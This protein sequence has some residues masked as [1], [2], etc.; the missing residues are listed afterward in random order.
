MHTQRV[1]A[2]VSL[3]TAVIFGCIA[4]LTAPFFTFATV[5]QWNRT[6]SFGARGQDV[7]E[8]Q[9]TLIAQGDL[10]TGNNTGYFG[11]LTQ[12]AV[13]KFQCRTNIICSGSPSTTGY[14]TVGPR[15]RAKILEGFSGGNNTSASNI[16]LYS[17]RPAITEDGTSYLYMSVLGTGFSSA[18]NFVT[19]TPQDPNILPAYSL[20]SIAL[21]SY[22]QGT[23]INLTLNSSPSQFSYGTCRTAGGMCQGSITGFPAGDYYV[24]VTNGDCSG[25]NCESNKV[26]V[27]IKATSSGQN[28][29]GAGTP[30]VTVLSPN[31]GEQWSI[32]STHTITWNSNNFSGGV[33]TIYLKNYDYNPNTDN[34]QT[35]YLLAH[36]APNTGNF[37]WTVPSTSGGQTLTSGSNYKIYIAANVNGSDGL[38][39]YDATIQDDLSDAPFTIKN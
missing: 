4:L 2:S 35:Q 37:T 39:N 38:I 32:G 8:L 20:R 11:R 17:V 14:G 27:N 6:L 7:I 13:Q 19:F 36:Y 34:N 18:K 10:A 12:V 15:T 1:F 24:S 5:P 9:N 25:A 28:Q 29:T 33:V 23:A 3:S 22:A 26:L 21:P 31:G 30:S 16:Q